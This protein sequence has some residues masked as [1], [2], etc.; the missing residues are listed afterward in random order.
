MSRGKCYGRGEVSDT[1]L[2]DI[3]RRF[4][5]FAVPEGIFDPSTATADQLMQFG[6]PPKPDPECQPLLRRAWDIGFGKPLRLQPF[7]VERDLV[8]QAEYRLFEKNVANISFDGNNFEISSNWSGAYI[9]ANQ[10]KHFL[11]I[12]GTWTIPG[13]LQVPPQRLQGPTGIPYVCANWIGLD[14]QRLYLD[15]SLPQMGTVSVLQ[16]DNTTTAQAWTQWWARDSV[17]PAPVP[18]GFSVAPGDRI[19]SVLT[20]VDPSTVNCVMVNSITRSI[21]TMRGSMR[22]WSISSSTRMSE[23]H[24]RSCWISTT[25]TFRCT[26]RRKAGSS[27]AIITVLLPAAL[28]VLRSAPASGPPTA[29]KRRGQ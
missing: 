24:V 6:L 22:C 9:T 12:W 26:G 10:D 11:Q 16:P 4:A 2:A 7:E 29:R 21:A 25:P 8:E 1:V 23:R 15:S 17:D 13:N 19:L 18:L 5:G 20:A 3:E 27:M 14:G 28:R